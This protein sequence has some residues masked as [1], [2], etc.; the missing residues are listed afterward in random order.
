MSEAD[1]VAVAGFVVLF[2]LMKILGV[3]FGK[4]TA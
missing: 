2:G 4:S 1:F 3:F